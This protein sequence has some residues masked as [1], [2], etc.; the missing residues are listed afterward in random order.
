MH[1]SKQNYEC[2]ELYLT[3][4][5]L[6]SHNFQTRC[7]CVTNKIEFLKNVTGQSDSLT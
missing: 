7:R 3:D 5:T 2:N 1:F 4:G 6:G